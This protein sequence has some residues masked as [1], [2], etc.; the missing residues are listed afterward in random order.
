MI[1]KKKSPLSEF[2]EDDKEIIKEITITLA[3]EFAKILENLNV[4]DI[5]EQSAKIASSMQYSTFIAYTLHLIYLYHDQGRFPEEIKSEIASMLIKKHQEVFLHNPTVMSK[6]L[7]MSENYGVT[8]KIKDKK[9]IKTQSPKSIPRK[10]KIGRSR[11]VGRYVVS[12]LTSTAEDYK[13]VLSNSRAL[14]LINSELL[15]YGLLRNTYSTIIT[16]A[17][18]AFEEGDEN[19]YDA[20]KMFKILF[21]NV[22]DTFLRVPKLFQ[23]RIKSLSERK[24]ESLR[25]EVISYLVKNPS[26]S[27]FFI[28]SLSKLAN[29]KLA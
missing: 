4:R 8:L 12:K 20:L 13:R 23:R 10:P 18:L 11:R 17:F 19:F 21:P 3:I 25:H 7:K 16:E 1:R 28:F 15:K 6:V 27:V 29:Y 9:N 14:D 5:L 2:T 26:S 24:K 22:D